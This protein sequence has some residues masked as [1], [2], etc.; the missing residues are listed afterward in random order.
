[1]HNAGLNHPLFEFQNIHGYIYD[2]MGISNFAWKKMKSHSSFWDV[3]Y[4]RREVL[5]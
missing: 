1:M 4:Y 3:D 5:I 2:G